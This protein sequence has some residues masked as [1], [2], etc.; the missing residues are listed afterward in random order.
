M[1][2]LRGGL[3]IRRRWLEDK[4][5][6][7]VLSISQSLPGL[8]A[9]NV[10]ILVGDRLRGT[11]GATAAV[12]GIGLPGGIW[13]FIAGLMYRAHGDHAWVTAALKGVAAA[14]VGLICQ[15]WCN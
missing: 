1:P 11:L 4:E 10:A 7:E 3:V 8:H 2:Y 13:M 6:V 5:F 12:V 14:S 15:P 9:T